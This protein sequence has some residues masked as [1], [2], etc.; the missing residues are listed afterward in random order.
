MSSSNA[1]EPGSTSS[2]RPVENDRK[3]KTTFTIQSHFLD[4]VKKKKKK[5]TRLVYR[6]DKG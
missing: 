6:E 3:K 5:S 4:E 1:V 2:I